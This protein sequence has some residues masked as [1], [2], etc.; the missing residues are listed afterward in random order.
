VQNIIIKV[1][2]MPLPP[3][4]DPDPDPDEVDI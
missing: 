4:P 2:T 1:G 3:S